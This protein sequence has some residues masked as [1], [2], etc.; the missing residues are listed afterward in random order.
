MNGQRASPQTTCRPLWLLLR[1]ALALWLGVTAAVVAR[2][3]RLSVKIYTTAD[4]LVS[5]RISRP[6]QRRNQRRPAANA[7]PGRRRQ[8]PRRFT[9]CAVGHVPAT[10]TSQIKNGGRKNGVSYF[11]VRHFFCLMA[12]ITIKVHR[13]KR[14][15]PGEDTYSAQ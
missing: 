6:G 14:A 9:P 1:L 5:N 15:A 7:R 2:A 12:E 13:Y 8:Q 3:E 11:S 4:G 10:W